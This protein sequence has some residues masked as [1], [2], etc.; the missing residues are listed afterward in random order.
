MSK[1]K[2]DFG[3]L[4]SSYELDFV[5]SISVLDMIYGSNLGAQ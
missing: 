1:W 4:R 2:D 5:S 3:V